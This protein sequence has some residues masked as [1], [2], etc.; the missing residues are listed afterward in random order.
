MEGLLHHFRDLSE[1]S[2][3]RLYRARLISATTAQRDLLSLTSAWLAHMYFNSNRFDE[4]VSSLCVS[5]DALE[6][7]NV[8]ATCRLSMIVGDIYANLGEDVL[9]RDW[10]TISRQAATSYGDQASIGALTY[11]SAALCVFA[12][13]LRA[14]SAAVSEAEVESASTRIRTAT[15]YQLIAQLT[16]LDHLLIGS[17]IHLEMIRQNF[18]I[19]SGFIEEILKSGV[20]PDEYSH[21]AIFKLDRVLCEVKLGRE[22]A[23]IDNLSKISLIDIARLSL[24]DQIIAHSTLS[25]I[26]KYIEAD[27]LECVQKVEIKR[28]I[29]LNEDSKRRIRGIMGP[30]ESIPVGFT[31]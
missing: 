18:G 21:L 14:C 4:A 29:E 9:S 2:L 10:Y 28:L 27:H 23:A 22:R 31:Q 20:A 30:F 5:L 15:N 26:R 17:N 6:T 11:N 7:T 24:D 16:S 8:A 1:K 19:A 3:D 13:R 12:L 25:N